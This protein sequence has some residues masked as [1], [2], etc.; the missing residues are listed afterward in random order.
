[1][2]IVNER[3]FLPSRNDAVRPKRVQVIRHKQI[4]FMEQQ[5]QEQTQLKKSVEQNTFLKKQFHS[6]SMITAVCK[7]ETFSLF[8]TNECNIKTHR[9]Q[10]L[11]NFVYALIG[12]EIIDYGYGD[13]FHTRVLM[14]RK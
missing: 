7:R 3:D 2:R 11:T 9:S 4:L 14:P 12:N 1:M 13:F 8:T 10:R 6:F 5:I